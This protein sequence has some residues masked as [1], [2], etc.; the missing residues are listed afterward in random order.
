MKYGIRVRDVMAKRLVTV[1]PSTG[2]IPAAKFM[3]KNSV[4]AL[5]VVQNGQ[6]V[7][8]VTDGDIIKKVIAA[9]KIPARVKISE[10]MTQNPVCVSP[11]DDLYTVSKLMN[12]KGIKRVF[13]RENGK[14]IGYL[15]ERDLLKVQPGIMDVLLEKLRI[16]QPSYRLNYK[17]R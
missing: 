12:E 16:L 11:D 10:I 3:R 6:L 14:L 8:I 7:G 13:V 17:E 2:L 5:G 4:G 9:G 15:S 1:K